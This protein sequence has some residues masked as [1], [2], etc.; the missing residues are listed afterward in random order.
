MSKLC[1]I[2]GVFETLYAFCK[3]GS[4]R[5]LSLWFTCHIGIIR[6]RSAPLATPSAPRV[7]LTPM[8]QHN[9]KLNTCTGIC[10]L[11]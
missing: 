5:T 11:S 10:T 4:V 3:G 9:N 7:R 2:A 1:V 8:C 6:Q